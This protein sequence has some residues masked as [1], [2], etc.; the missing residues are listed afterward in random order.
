[1]GVAG[2]ISDYSSASSSGDAVIRTAQTSRNLML[3]SGGEAPAIYIQSLDM[4]GNTRA[5]QSRVG[6]G[7]TTPEAVFTVFRRPQ[8]ILATDVIGDNTVD[9]LLLYVDS[10]SI[11]NQKSNQTIR[12]PSIALRAGSVYTSTQKSAPGASMTISGG[13]EVNGDAVPGVITFNTALSASPTVTIGTS[14]TIGGAMTYF[15]Y[16]TTYLSTSSMNISSYALSA[17]GNIITS[18]SFIATSD[19]RIKKNIVEVSGE[20]SLEVLDKIQIYEY[21]MRD[22]VK[23]SGRQVGV[24]A[25]QV[26]KVLPQAVK[27]GEDDYVADLLAYVKIVYNDGVECVIQLF[28]PVELEGQIRLIN[29]RNEKVDVRVV[30]KINS[31]LYQISELID[32]ERQWMIYGT[33]QKEI[34]AVDKPM[35][36]MLAISAIQQLSREVKEMRE[37]IKKLWEVVKR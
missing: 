13:Q 36:G 37:E 19:Q 32:T 3:Q 15:G 34:L 16:N 7:S 18:G 27:K 26:Q 10:G 25:Q 21:E 6:I 20:R 28:D 31:S 17:A 35:L 29:E 30:R 14:S 24:I 8:T 2:A 9:N 11:I 22:W 23:E 4:S 5:K 12:A 1:M 33:L